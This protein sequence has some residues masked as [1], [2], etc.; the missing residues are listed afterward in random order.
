MG[1]L[2]FPSFRRLLALLICMTAFR[3]TFERQV[4][5]L[6]RHAEVADVDMQ[7]FAMSGFY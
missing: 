2:E 7:V 3:G 1:E 5:L 4:L 6:R